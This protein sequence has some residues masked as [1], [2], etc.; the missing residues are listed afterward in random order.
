MSFL[1]RRDFIKDSAV[2]AALAGAGVVGKATAAKSAKAV[3]A[4]DGEGALRVA[5]IGVHGR[6]QDHVHGFAGK[7]NCIV[8]VI[9]DVDSAVIDGAM[10]SAE[11]AQGSAPKYE[12]DLRKVIE[13]KN[14][15]VIS[16][17]TPNHWHS[18]AAIW[19]LQNGKD[20]YVEKPVSHNV[21]EGRRVVDFARKENRICQAG[22]QSRSSTGLQEAM[23]FLRDGKLGKISLARG[24]C[25]K[26]RGSIGKVN[27]P[28]EPPKTM[29]Y[30][31]WCGPAPHNPPLRN[32]KF[33]T[34][35]YDWHW[36][37]DYGCGD[38]GNQGIHEM[39]K[40]RWALGKNELSSGV[41]SVGGRFGY[42]DDAETPNTQISVFDYGDS[43][44]IF[45]VRGLKTDPL[46]KVKVGNIIYGSEGYLVITDYANAIAFTKD[47]EKIKEFKGGGD[48]FGNFAK[49]VRSR[50]VGDL[51]ADILDGHLSSALCHLGNIS[52]RLGAQQPFRTGYT[53]LG[54]DKEATEAFERM[55]AHLKDN[56]VEPDE[57]RY[58]IGRKLKLD[59]KTET[60]I[61]DKEADALLT[62][63]YRKGF[64]LPIAKA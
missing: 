13:D 26:P 51:N 41:V 1:N 42:I 5:V 3:K 58:R 17:A 29:D 38:L 9:C 44:L 23:Q 64:E 45:E 27:G 47:G 40:C 50:K 35:H 32:T 24:L 20:V 52:Y 61:G 53:G 37:W 39:D 8:T 36:F 7:N 11:K 33:G 55:E 6:G 21:S 59:P 2:L 25:Y 16:I 34:V 43:E 4:A 15:D 63:E 10:T 56:K 49:A 60:F 31:L 28:Q 46:Q 54:D 18:L 48:H 14:I 12:Q 19:G 22:T 57:T 62:R 30:D